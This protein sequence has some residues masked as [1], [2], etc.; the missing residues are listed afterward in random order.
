MTATILRAMPEDADVLAALGRETFAETFGHMYPPEDLVQFLAGTY[1]PAVFRGFLE[2]P[3]QALWKAEAGGRAVGYAQ[4]GRCALPHPDVTPACGEL[5]RLYVKHG[6][7]NGGMGSALLDAALAWL[8]KPGRKLWIGV[9][10][11]NTGAQRLYSRRGFVKVG[12]YAFAVG[13]TR[14]KEFILRRG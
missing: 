2:D 3:T 8:H 4:A 13:S 5:K 10:S 1:T 7:Q 6:T 14:D 9:W 12:E 11:E